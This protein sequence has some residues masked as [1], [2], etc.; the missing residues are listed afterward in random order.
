MPNPRRRRSSTRQGMVRS[1][2]NLTPPQS[3]E[4]P[5]CGEPKMPHRMCP[6]CGQYK[7]RTYEV[8]VTQ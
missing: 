3:I 2:K 4:C 7:S 8:K 6:S 1:Q 5:N